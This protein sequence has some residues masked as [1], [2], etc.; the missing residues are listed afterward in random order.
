MDYK[1]EKELKPFMET[2]GKLTM[3]N[4]EC[5]Q[6]SVQEYY[7]SEYPLV[8]ERTKYVAILH[9]LQES[10]MVILKEKINPNKMKMWKTLLNRFREAKSHSE[11]GELLKD[12]TKTRIR[13]V[14]KSQQ[15]DKTFFETLRKVT[16]NEWTLCNMADSKNKERY[17]MIY[18]KAVYRI[19]FNID[20]YLELQLF[21]A[22]VQRLS[23][24]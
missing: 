8:E 15:D 3:K 2:A 6:K 13:L 22:S 17:F 12:I 21:S 24:T 20:L 10:T 23:G 19:L 4:N 14:G 7:I 16:K 1:S 18:R 11:F 9:N 5:Y